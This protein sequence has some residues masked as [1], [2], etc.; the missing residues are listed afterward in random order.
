MNPAEAYI[1]EQKEP[2]RGIFLELQAAIQR[3][4]PQAVLRFKYRIPF[5]YLKDK[6]FCYLNQ[7]GDYVDLGIVNGALLANYQHIL[8]A[9]KRKQVRS[10]RFRNLSEIDPVVLHEVLSDALRISR[11]SY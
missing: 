7:S 3:Q 2:Y 1:L 6:P 5:Y 9:E 10:L 4:V 11:P 8:V